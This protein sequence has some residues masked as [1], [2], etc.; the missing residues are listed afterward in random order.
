MLFFIFL[1]SF[2]QVL[3]NEQTFGILQVLSND[4]VVSVYILSNLVQR[5]RDFIM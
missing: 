1:A 2:Y 4:L 3:L 5:I